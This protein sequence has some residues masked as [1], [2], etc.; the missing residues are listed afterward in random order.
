MLVDNFVF[1][2]LTVKY[3]Y[4]NETPTLNNIENEILRVMTECDCVANKEYRLWQNLADYTII[5][6]SISDRWIYCNQE[7]IARRAVA[8]YLE[9]PS[10][11]NLKTLIE[12]YKLY[13]IALKHVDSRTDYLNNKNKSTQVHALG[14]V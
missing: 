8:M 11:A 6:K 1:N 13:I 7:E 3:L 9:P 2:I 5:S 4:V 14:L 12:E 10:D